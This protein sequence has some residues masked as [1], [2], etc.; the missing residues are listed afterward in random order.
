MTITDSFVNDPAPIINKL[1]LAL[2]N[3]RFYPSAHSLV[4]ESIVDLHNLLQTALTSEKGLS[5]GFMESKL[6]VNGQ[7]VNADPSQTKSLARHFEILHIGTV[8]FQNGLALPE[9]RSFLECLAIKP[10]KLN[11]AGGLKKALSDHALEHVIISDVQY[12]RINKK[13]MEEP[14]VDD[15]YRKALIKASR[16]I[17]TGDP[18]FNADMAGTATTSAEPQGRQPSPEE[19]KELYAIR[20]RFQ[21]EL[22]QK[23][24][25]A[26]RHYEVENKRLTFEKG[27]MDSI[28]RNVGE[29]VVV[30][31]NDGNIIMANPAAEKL[32]SKQGRAIVGQTLKESLREEHSLVLSGGSPESIKEIEV[33]GKDEETRR[34]LRSSNAVVED[35]DGR[36]IGMVSVLSDITK[37]KEVEQ[38]KSDFVANVS[39]ELRSPLAAIQKNLGLILD[40][41]AGVINTNQKEFLSLAKDNVERLTRLINDLLDLSKIEAGKMELKKARTDLKALARNAV[42]A[43]TG[44]FH[45][46]GIT[47]RLDVPN[48]PVDLEVDADKITQVMNNLLSNALKF[49]PPKGEIRITLNAAVGPIE[50]SVTDT[51][52][53]IGPKDIQRIFNK[54]EQVSAN[55]PAGANG[56]GLGLPLAKQIVEKHGGCMQ[57]KSEIGKGSTFSFTLPR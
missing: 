14:A 56:T 44:W 27:T 53:G 41:T 7:L 36:T 9:L 19:L 12:G 33:A 2:Q 49:T 34:V 45:E 47:V 10:E 38:L 13:D 22:D 18:I 32:L 23:V 46:K 54:F 8:T 5:F 30:I 42:T 26:T 37:M 4:Q 1:F 20:A 25:E 29:G 52:I 21:A 39:H 48:T 43:F 50:V 55:H 57:V 35:L 17:P 24:H 31:G 40:Q 6:M 11:E 51:G 28:M 16:N 3:V 15:D